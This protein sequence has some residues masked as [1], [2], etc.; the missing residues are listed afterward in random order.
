M[1]TSEG[2]QLSPQQRW[3]WQ[4][5]RECAPFVSQC[6]KVIAGPLQIERRRECVAHS[7]IVTRSLRVKPTLI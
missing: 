2:Y 6:A 7:C 5:Q 3:V 4:L 1:E